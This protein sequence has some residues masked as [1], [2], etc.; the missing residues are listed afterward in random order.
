MRYAKILLILLLPFSSIASDES[1]ES[2]DYEKKIDYCRELSFREINKI[3]D[4]YF[5]SLDDRHKGLLIG[6]LYFK[7]MDN[8]YLYEEMQYFRYV[9]NS[10][11]KEGMKILKIISSPLEIGTLDVKEIERLSKTDMF[12]TPFD[13]WK[14]I[15]KLGL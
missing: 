8:C 11:D 10:D 5:N 3:E 7:A 2:K 1:K 15:D 6:S 4:P 13:H 12:S 14:L 9:I